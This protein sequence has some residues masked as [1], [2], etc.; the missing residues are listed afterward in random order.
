MK[1]LLAGLVAFALSV[2]GAHFVIAQQAPAA[3]GG[4]QQAG[5]GAAAPAQ[6]VGILATSVGLGKGATLGG[7]AG[8]DAHCQALATAAGQGSRTWRAYLSTTAGGNAQAVNA[9]G[10][11]GPATG[12][13]TRAGARAKHI[14]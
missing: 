13:N 10:R 7:L 12:G 2:A 1:R 14:A 5:R 3:G 6:P 11:I 4:A 9:R 8:A